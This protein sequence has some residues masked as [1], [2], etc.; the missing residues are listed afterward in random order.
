MTN[1]QSQT[2]PAVADAAPSAWPDSMDAPNYTGAGIFL[3]DVLWKVRGQLKV[4]G[5]IDPRATLDESFVEGLQTI[6][7]EIDAALTYHETRRTPWGRAREI[8]AE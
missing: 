8:G 7:S 5:S 2:A 4:L 3:E 1:P 6:V